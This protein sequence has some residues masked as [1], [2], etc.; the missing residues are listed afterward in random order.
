M[1]EPEQQRFQ[2]PPA[3]RSRELLKDSLEQA[4]KADREVIAG[5]SMADRLALTLDL[6]EFATRNANVAAK[7]KRP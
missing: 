5:M 4:A 2:K 7:R 1:P 3:V 6:S